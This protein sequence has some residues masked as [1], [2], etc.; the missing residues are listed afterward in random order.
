MFKKITT[1][2]NQMNVEFNSLSKADVFR[3]K[4]QIFNY[5]K[6]DNQS[7]VSYFKS[8]NIDE[9]TLFIKFILS[10][11][12]KYHDYYE[13]FII[14]CLQTLN[15]KSLFEIQLLFIGIEYLLNETII[16]QTL[17]RSIK[18]DRNEFLMKCLSNF[19]KLNKKSA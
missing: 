13:T 15:I 11:N 4:K 3:H 2:K 9:K 14:H 5:F 7:S 16:N 6:I 12:D 8:L 17:S 1:L 19:N 10:N 18:F